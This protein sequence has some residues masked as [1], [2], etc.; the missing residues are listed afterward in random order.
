LTA[1]DIPHIA[2]ALSKMP[3]LVELNLSCNWSLGGSGE[4]WAHL[5]EVKQI[6]KIN[7]GLCDL[8]ADDIPHIAAALINMPKLV[9]LDLS[10]NT[11]AHV[12]GI[13]SHLAEVTHLQRLHL[14]EVRLYGD[15]IE[16]MTEAL[17]AMENLVELDLSGNSDL[18][19]SGDSWLSLAKMKNIQKLSLKTCFLTDDDKSRIAEVKSKMSPLLEVEY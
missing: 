14:C 17:S 7:L 16:Q 4:A 19:L 18:S 10:R 11:I 13:W 9:E 1:D 6:K 12:S 3:K 15:D 5:A 8:T 2:A